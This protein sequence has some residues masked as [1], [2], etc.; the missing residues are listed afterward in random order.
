MGRGGCQ[1]PGVSQVNVSARAS[2]VLSC[3]G[4]HARVLCIKQ[5]ILQHMQ[6]CLGG[7]RGEYEHAT[8]G[9]RYDE[10]AA[11]TFGKAVSGMFA[12]A[13]GKSIGVIEG[14]AK[15]AEVLFQDVRTCRLAY[16]PATCSSAALTNMQPHKRA[17]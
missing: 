14:K 7:A 15:D 9:R 10:D 8:D 12:H 2:V 5:R 16:V 1:A 13:K 4:C 3:T 11:L 6:V 17:S